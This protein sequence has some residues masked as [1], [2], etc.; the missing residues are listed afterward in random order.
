MYHL[1]DTFNDRRI[2]S[3]RTL[4]AAIE[5]DRKYDRA[6]KRANGQSSYIPTQYREGGNQRNWRT[7]SKPVDIDDVY[8]ERQTTWPA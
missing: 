6:V 7:E 5:A 4:K 1:I 3:H 8:Y 2:S